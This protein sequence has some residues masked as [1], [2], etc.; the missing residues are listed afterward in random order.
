MLGGLLEAGDV[1]DEP[2][3]IEE[4]ESFPLP[5][6]NDTEIVKTGHRD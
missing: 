2:L 3:D 4:L 1:T 5:G 6:W